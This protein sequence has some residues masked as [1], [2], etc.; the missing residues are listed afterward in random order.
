MID[1][2]NLRT[3][4]D[5]FNPSFLGY[6]RSN[7]SVNVGMRENSVGMRG[8]TGQNNSEYGHFSRSEDYF[9]SIEKIIFGS[10]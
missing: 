3:F 2:Q 6:L 10:F 8:N 1:R 4:Q 5:I 7:P 9:S